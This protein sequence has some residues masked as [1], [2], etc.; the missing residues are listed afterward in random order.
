MKSFLSYLLLFFH[1]CAIGQT[2]RGT[3][4][5]LNIY[6]SATSDAARFGLACTLSDEYLS[7]GNFSASLE[8][9]QNALHLAEKLSVDT[10]LMR[11]NLQTGKICFYTGLLEKSV[12]YFHNCL[13]LADKTGN[14]KLLATGNFNLGGIYNQ[15][16]DLA[17]SREYTER[18][19]EQMRQ[20]HRKEGTAIPDYNWLTYHINIGLLDLKEKKYDSSAHHYRTALELADRLNAQLDKSRV[21]SGYADLLTVTGKLDSALIVLELQ[22]ANDRITGNFYGQNLNLLQSAEIYLKKDQLPTA[23][24][25]FHAAMVEAKPRND[26]YILERVC[27][28]LAQIYRKTS[29][30]DSALFYVDL[31]SQYRTASQKEKGL[32]TAQRQELERQFNSREN[33]FQKVMR[34]ERILLLIAIILSLGAVA[35]LTLRFR[36]KSR[37]KEL[38]LSLQAEKLKLLNEQLNLK[39]KQL[40]A[41]V[42]YSLQRN[43]LIS[44][45]VAKFQ[46][47][48]SEST[49]RRKEGIG[50]ILKDLEQNGQSDPWQEFEQ[51]FQEVH[52]GFYERLM[53]KFPDLTAN[54][55]RLCAFLRLDMSTKEI[56]NLTGQSIKAITQARFRL[57]SKLRI[58]NPDTSLFEVLLQI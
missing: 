32:Q 33:S 40:A 31:E 16:G 7:A 9:A 39:D 56:S 46:K 27:Q 8:Y 17:K 38:E 18:A 29:K 54:E 25:L 52:T 34:S 36:N 4:S 42:M 22:A 41:Q 43:E 6:K 11:G 28:G 1:F 44:D 13:T 19:M 20:Y 35:F 50:K 55:R 21:L 53:E 48:E 24:G 49:D 26:F 23:V 30:P 14:M 10:L 2:T 3:D 45:L 12:T 58:E 5:L 47:L 51:R 57:R 15:L 37:L